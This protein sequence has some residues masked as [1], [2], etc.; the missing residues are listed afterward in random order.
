VPVGA[1]PQPDGHTAVKVDGRRLR[2]QNNRE[3]VI[4]ALIAL[5]EEGDYSPSTNDVAERAGIS[6]RSLFRYFD[7]VDD[8]LRAAI[9]R[10]LATAQPVLDL[11]VT[12]DAPVAMKIRR[13]VERRVAMHE[14]LTP[15]ARASRIAAHRS[16]VITRQLRAGRRFLGNQIRQLFPEELDGERA[17]LLPAIDALLSYETHDLLR[18]THGMSRERTQAALMTA[19]TVLIG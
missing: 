19:L 9:Q 13:L 7:D 3:A 2:R 11:G 8:L 4:D 1:T 14:A 6:A 15:T 17:D 10:Q 5:L 16:S 12:A 18:G